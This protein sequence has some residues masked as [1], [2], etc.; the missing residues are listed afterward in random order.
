MQLD[1]IEPVRARRTDPSTSHEAAARVSEFAQCHQTLILAAL[2]RFGRA[3]AEQLAAA[4][5]LDAYQ[6]RKRL[7]E[8]ESA[9]AAQPTG[10]TRKTV[11]GRSE[12]V[13]SA[14]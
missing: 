10:D 4:T 8:L 9:G 5:R 1:L 7:S 11:S 2:R 3:G 12:R 14:L 6:V 13:W